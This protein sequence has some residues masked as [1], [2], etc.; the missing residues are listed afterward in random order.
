[1]VNPEHALS[2]AREAQLL[3]LS[4]ASLYS[5]PVETCEADL[6]VMR[7]IDE[8]PLQWPFI[9]RRMHAR[10]AAAERRR[11]RSQACGELNAKNGH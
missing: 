1:M 10:H 6:V 2:L 5:K 9:G 11:C 4:R 7:R 8:M 3:D